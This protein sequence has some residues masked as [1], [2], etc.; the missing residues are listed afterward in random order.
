MKFMLKSALMWAIPMSVLIGL[1]VALDPMLTL[2]WHPDMMPDRFLPNKG[3]VTVKQF[4]HYN[5]EKHYDSFI[6]GASISINHWLEDWKVYL[7][8]DAVPY[9]FDLS[10]MTLE[11]M[12]D[13]VEY[14]AENS[15]ARHMLIV[16]ASDTPLW[17]NSD[18]LAFYI[19]G[20]MARGWKGKMQSLYVPFMATYNWDILGEMAI[21]RFCGLNGKMIK[22]LYADDIDYYD[23]V[24]NEERDMWLEDSL[25]IQAAKFNPADGVA[26]EILV[27]SSAIGDAEKV[28]L[29]RIHSAITG[30]DI[31]A[32]ILVAP[33]LSNVAMCTEDSLFMAELFGDRFIDL[34]R[35]M[36]HLTANP[37]LWYDGIHYRPPVARELMDA[38]YK[39]KARQ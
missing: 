16:M 33:K 22:G 8:E 32:I 27:Q 23:P 37:N 11:G 14:L 25:A 19:P 1:Y 31:D 12:A 9:H 3:N 4:E 20:E 2:R 7:P 36:N 6:I 26:S 17:E 5:P 24:G 34:S 18:R 39:R 13:A 35:E 10:M 15:D 28:F 21:H 38:A 30:H 29:R